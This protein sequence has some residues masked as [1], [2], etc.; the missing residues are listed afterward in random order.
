MNAQQAEKLSQEAD[1]LRNQG[2]TDEAK[3]KYLEAA[4]I[5]A[6]AG[7]GVKAIDCRYLLIAT[8]LHME[9]NLEESKKLA[10][11]GAAKFAELGA[12]DLE[13]AAYI[14]VGIAY[15]IDGQLAEAKEWFKKAL[16]TLQ[17]I[18]SSTGQ[19]N[20]GIAHAKLGYTYVKEGRFDEAAHEFDEAL[21]ILRRVGHWFFEHTTLMHMA[22]MYF[23]QE[24]YK[25]ALTYAQASL[26]LIYQEGALNEHKRRVAELKGEIAYCYWSFGNEGA[27]TRFLSETIQLINEMPND[28]AKI[29]CHNIKAQELLD[30]IAKRRPQD[31]SKLHIKALD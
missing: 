20:F 5:F 22:S 10:S 26:A 24:N 27:G 11:E 3:S 30:K 14:N 25:D 6:A 31:R 8:C 29:V 1:V 16:E 23:E 21:E 18:H 28:V 17:A 7:E 2:K 13:G 12:H 19:A 15:F 4:S 9:G